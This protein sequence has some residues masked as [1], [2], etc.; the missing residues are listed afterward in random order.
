M[1][2]RQVHVSVDARPTTC[3]PGVSREGA[4]NMRRYR[5]VIAVALLGVG[6]GLSSAWAQIVVTDPGTT[7]RNTVTA[8]LKSHVLETLTEQ[9]RVLR[10][11]ARRLSVHTSLE[12]YALPDPPRWRTHGSDAFLYTREFNEALIFGDATGM[13]YVAVS[14]S[15]SSAEEVLNRLAPQARRTLV[16]QLATLDAADATA[17][18][19]IDQTGRLR[20]NGRKKELPAIDALE[21]DVIDPSQEQSATAVL[22]K[23]SVAKL[24]EVRQKQA[25]LQLLSAIVEQLLVDDKRARDT[26][27]AALNMQLSRLPVVRDD[28]GRGSLAG[29]GNELRAWRQP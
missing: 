3:A 15:L 11:M 9:R 27:A 6:L 19:A 29:A 5:V 10:R 13:A 21:A 7:A 24:L 16:A 18:A 25:R 23:I 22:D 26:E 14:R 4:A 8:V 2:G 20:F 1:A 28:S 17:I 12:K